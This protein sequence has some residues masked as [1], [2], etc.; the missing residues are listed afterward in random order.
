MSAPLIVATSQL[1][2]LRIGGAVIVIGL[3]ILNLPAFIVSATALKFSLMFVGA[4]TM[5]GAAL[6]VLRSVRCPSCDLAWLQWTLGHQPFDRWLHWLMEFRECPRCG[7]AAQG[8][9]SV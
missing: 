7:H 1:R 2:K 5:I 8:H 4:F 3:G 9:H 6:Y